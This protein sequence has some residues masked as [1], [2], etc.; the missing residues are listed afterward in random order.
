MK[1]DNILIIFFLLFIF[2]ANH[3]MF[4]RPPKVHHQ[5]CIIKTLIIGPFSLPLLLCTSK[6]IRSQHLGILM[7]FLFLIT[8]I[9]PT[10]FSLT[11]GSSSQILQHL[12]LTSLSYILNLLGK[13]NVSNQTTAACRYNH[14]PPHLQDAHQYVKDVH[15]T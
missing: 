15:E 8:K 2:K 1:Q 12:D 10:V 9:A 3:S 13:I 5:E 14:P 4:I 7:S 6:C 11:Y